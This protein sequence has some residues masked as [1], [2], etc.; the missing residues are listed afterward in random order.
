MIR[1]PPRS[2][3]F[4]YTTL[5]RARRLLDVAAE[6]VAHRREHLLREGVLPARAEAREEG[7][8]E[9]VAGNGFLERRHDRPAPLA[10]VRDDA[11]VGR[12][13]RVLGE[14]LRREVQEPGADEIGRAHV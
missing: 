9:D 5:F 6:L 11:G 12:E 3:L 4:P 10:G 14:R 7:G 2:T 8:G 1:R 13:G